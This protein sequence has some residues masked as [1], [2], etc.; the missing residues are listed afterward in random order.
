LSIA[1]HDT[2]FLNI[3]SVSIAV[4]WVRTVAV[5]FV[6]IINPFTKI[7]DYII[8]FGD[9]VHVL[10]AIIPAT[11]SSIILKLE[12]LLGSRRGMVKM[13]YLLC[14]YLPFA[15]IATDTYRELELIS[16]VTRLRMF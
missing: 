15:L 5:P 4:V 6:P 11:L 9:E 7:Y 1:G 2:R 16:P 8:T 10:I 3:N 13:L 14:R 12:F